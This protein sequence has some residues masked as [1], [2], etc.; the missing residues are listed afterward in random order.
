MN[1]ITGPGKYIGTNAERLALPFYGVPAGS[2]F[3]ETDTRNEYIFDGTNWNNR[4]VI[5]IGRV[6]AQE[7]THAIAEG[8]ISG[9]ESFSKFGYYSAV[10]T[11]Q[12][13][14]WSGGSEYV[15]PVSANA[16]HLQSTSAEDSAAGSGV[17]TVTIFYLDANYVTASETVTLNGTAIVTT[18]ATNVL[19][20]NGIWAATTGGNLKASG[21]ISL[22]NAADSV[23]YTSIE[24]GYTRDRNSVYTVPLG[25]ILYVTS[26]VIG[27]HS[28][29]KGMRY[30]LKSTYDKKI[31]AVK[32]FFYPVAETATSN[33]TFERR[34]DMP[35]KVIA[36]GSIKMSAIADQAGAFCT[37]AYRGWM[38]DA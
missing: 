22:K 17:R 15:F 20:I 26:F 3:L 19:R 28:A 18:T 24:A 36:T 9:H 37:A 21:T 11:T 32:T 29:G 14:L 16:T 13:D 38:E 2:T 33:G 30:T 25:K 7:Y 4:S 23:T 8:D 1:I 31:A 5:K 34:F 35:I 6:T 10:G 12:L 27:T